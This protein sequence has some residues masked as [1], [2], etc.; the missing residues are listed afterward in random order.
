M[1]KSNVA[2]AAFA[3]SRFHKWIRQMDA[4]ETDILA[5]LNSKGT[6]PPEAEVGKRAEAEREAKRAEE[7]DVA[8]KGLESEDEEVDQDL[9]KRGELEG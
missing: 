8:A 5:F 7:G 1:C 3:H 2:W 6:I 4:T 9:L